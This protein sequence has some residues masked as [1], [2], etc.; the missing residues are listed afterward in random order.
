[1]KFKILESR[2]SVSMGQLVPEDESWISG[3]KGRMAVVR[4]DDKSYSYFFLSTANIS[5]LQTYMKRT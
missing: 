5:N 4:D 3:S 2:A 1:M